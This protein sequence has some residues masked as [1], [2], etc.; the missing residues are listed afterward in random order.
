MG[1]Y[2]ENVPSV[3]NVLGGPKQL[4]RAFFVVLVN[5]VRLTVD[6]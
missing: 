6:R 4:F 5:F 1:C 3:I 2:H